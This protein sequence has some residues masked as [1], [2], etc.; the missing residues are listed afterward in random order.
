MSYEEAL[1]DNIEYVPSP[2]G[3]GT[4]LIPCEMNCGRKVKKYQYSRKRTYICDYCK[5]KIAEKK[6][7]FELSQ[8]IMDCRTKK[9]VQFDKAVE[10]IK[11]Q[12]DDFE[13]YEK[14]IKAAETRCEK[15]GSIPEAMV[16]IELLKIGFQ[17]IPQQKI[18][19]YKPDFVIPKQKLCIEVDGSV[20]HS[21]AN[22]KR[23]ATIQLSLG[24]DWKIIH[25]PAELIEKNI[26][27][28]KT[29][30]RMCCNSRS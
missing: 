23:E 11:Q 13:K 27:K 25:I 8:E 24:L 15:Y 12:V 29:I 10:R 4:Y 26:K 30:I 7:A 21:Q 20:Y 5:G 6:K 18:G 2:Y 17:I 3:R 9:E 1:L 22:N 19:R 28:L 16:A 14:A